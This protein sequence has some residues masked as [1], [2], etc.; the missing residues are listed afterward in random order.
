MQSQKK[1]DTGLKELDT[2]DLLDRWTDSYTFRELCTIDTKWLL[3]VIDTIDSEDVD[4]YKTMIHAELKKD[5]GSVLGHR[6]D[7]GL[8]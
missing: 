2:T 8:G 3:S 7:Y 4:E 1:P 5:I 6:S